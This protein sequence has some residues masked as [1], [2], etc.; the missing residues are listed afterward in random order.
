M[1]KG[2]PAVP[3]HLYLRQLAKCMLGRSCDQHCRF[4]FAKDNKQA[5]IRLASAGLQVLLDRLAAQ[6][7]LRPLFAQLVQLGELVCSTL[8][9]EPDAHE[10]QLAEIESIIQKLEA[11][12]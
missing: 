10:S 8:S 5:K 6:E 3:H 11:Q 9:E 4:L 1:S 2:I 12:R 7:A